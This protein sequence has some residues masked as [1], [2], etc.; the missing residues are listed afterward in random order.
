M[1]AGGGGRV[2]PETSEREILADLVSGKDRQRKKGNGVKR[3]KIEKARL[4][5]LKWKEKK[6]K[7]EER[8]PPFF[9]SCFSLFK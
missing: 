4:K 7:N 1:S 8:F 9:F 3:R 2:S 6:L 5:N